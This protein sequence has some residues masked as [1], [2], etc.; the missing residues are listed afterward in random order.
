MNQQEYEILAARFFDR[1]EADGVDMSRFK[2]FL[3]NPFKTPAWVLLEMSE[4]TGAE[5]GT[6]LSAGFGR[7]L[8]Y[9]TLDRTVSRTGRG[10]TLGVVM[11]V[12]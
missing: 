8:D 2:R 12:A 10:E 9:D 7:G 6:L 5:I 11:H 1:M 3:L 4:H